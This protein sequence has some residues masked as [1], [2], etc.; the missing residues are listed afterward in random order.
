[1]PIL[2][3]QGGFVDETVLVSDAADHAAKAGLWRTLATFILR[4]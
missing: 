3:K 4:P 2:K 1:M